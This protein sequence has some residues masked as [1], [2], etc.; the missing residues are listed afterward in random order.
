M[1]KMYRVLIASASEEFGTNL[2]GI[3]K[4]TDRYTVVGTAN[5]GIRA[6]ELLREAAPEILVTDMM[7]PKAD[8]VAVLKAANALDKKPMILVLADIMTEFISNLLVSLGVQYVL[9]K[10]CTGRSVL[11]RLDEPPEAGTD[12]GCQCGSDGYIDDP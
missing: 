10:P 8:G 12:S 5:D 11:E 4:Q 3:L 2:G 7:L 1:E 9:M 6:M